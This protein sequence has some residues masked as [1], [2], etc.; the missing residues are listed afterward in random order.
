M[1]VATILTLAL[2][3]HRDPAATVTHRHTTGR[4]TLMVHADR[5][6]G[7]TSC[8]LR[9]RGIAIHHDTAIFDLG[10]GVET[11]AAQFR[12]DGGRSHSVQDVTLE[13]AHHGVFPDRGWVDNPSRG[14]VA[15]PVSDVV[16]ARRVLI[17]A[18]PRAPI[19]SFDVSRLG[20]ALRSADG[21]GCPP[22]SL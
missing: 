10:R 21:L 20:E 22:A 17:R 11:D 5:F 1:I 3:G 8:S 7:Q 18:T 2:L 9:S 12:I 4:W 14:E 15:V 13:N 16:G 6:N 19:M